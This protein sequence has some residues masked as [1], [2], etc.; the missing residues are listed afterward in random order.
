MQVICTYVYTYTV[1]MYV[2]I[3]MYLQ[4]TKAMYGTIHSSTIVTLYIQEL[5]LNFKRE[6]GIDIKGKETSS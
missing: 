1:A 2:Y 4:N 3:H 5:N 6:V